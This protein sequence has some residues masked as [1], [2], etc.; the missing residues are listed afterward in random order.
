VIPIIYLACPAR[1][2]RASLALEEFVAAGNIKKFNSLGQKISTVQQTVQWDLLGKRTFS[3]VHLRVA[4]IL[5]F[6]SGKT[7]KNK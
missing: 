3:S 1:F 5:S 6:C 2:E 4:C 7:S